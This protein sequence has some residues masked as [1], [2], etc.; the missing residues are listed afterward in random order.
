MTPRR[1]AAATV[2]LFGAVWGCGGGTEPDA[3]VTALSP[4]MAFNDAATAVLIEGGPFRPAYR[5]DTM[6][7]ATNTQL[8]AF[9]VVLTPVAGGTASGV[10]PI[11]LDAVSWQAT[12]ALAA[13]VPAGIPEGAYDVAVTDPRGRRTVLPVGFTSLGADR[14]APTVT[15][16][17]P[18]AGSIIAAQTKVS[19]S[20]L[21]DDGPGLL[22]SLTVTIS[23]AA[24]VLQQTDCTVAAAMHRT[25]C[26]L[27]LTAPV[28]A[29]DGDV[30]TI[31]ARAADAAGNESPTTAIYP[32]V[33]RPTLVSL[34]PSVGPA[35]GGTQI[36]VQGTNFVIGADPDKGT[37]LLIDDRVVESA[38]VISATEIRATT[39]MHDAGDAHL[40]VSTGGA[41]TAPIIF[42]FVA[43]PIVRMVSPARGPLTGGTPIAIVGNHFRAGMT[44]VYIGQ[45]PLA[46]A[47]WVSVNRIEGTVPEG[48]AIGPTTVAAYD[49]V[50]GGSALL[51]GFAYDPVEDEPPDGGVGPGNCDGVP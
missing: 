47:R 46:C 39:P 27:S 17:A 11:T 43:A 5:F 21:A 7:A 15:I 30:L 37:R 34:S 31:E 8:S 51:D 38:E 32:L 9:S 29:G 26:P 19:V 44:R 25:P 45:L 24:G 50:G 16:Q 35:A 36:E 6:A 4:A 1:C 12:T 40:T 23:T 22:A 48:L 10:D 13:T 33:Q 49:P 2:S 42:E 28:P 14:E 41:G 3:V 20:V 18:A